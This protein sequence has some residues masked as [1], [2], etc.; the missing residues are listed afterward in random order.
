MIYHIT[1]PSDWQA[2][3]SSGQYQAASLSSEGFIHCSLAEQVERSANLHFAGQSSLIVL[4]IDDQ[5]TQSKVV[6]ENTS[7]G[8]ELFPHLYGPL[9]IAAEVRELPMEPDAE[10][11]FHFSS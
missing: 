2:A 9:E 5:K 7:G 8:Q 10:G 6:Y 1:T 11:R 3:Q 4:V